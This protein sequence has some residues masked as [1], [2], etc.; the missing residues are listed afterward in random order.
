MFVAQAL[1][2]TSLGLFSQKWQRFLRITADTIQVCPQVKQYYQKKEKRCMKLVPTSLRANHIIWWDLVFGLVLLVPDLTGASCTTDQQF[3][4]HL[5]QTCSDVLRWNMKI[6][7]VAT[8]FLDG[9]YYRETSLQSRHCENII[10]CYYFSQWNPEICHDT[11]LKWCL[12][13][14]LTARSH[15][16]SQCCPVP[17]SGS[18]WCPPYLTPGATQLPGLPFCYLSPI[19]WLG[20]LSRWLASA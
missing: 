8:S 1:F 5:V 17:P 11:V 16:R 12:A 18:C 6:M 14:R 15:D 3:G 10:K 4:T 19:W 2:L 13:V 7:S 20:L 9:H